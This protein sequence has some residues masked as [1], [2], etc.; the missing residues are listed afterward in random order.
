MQRNHI[1]KKRT[2][3]IVKR[4]FKFKMGTSGLFSLK[5]QR[6]ELV[7]IRGFKKMMRRKYL[8]G[9]TRFRFRKI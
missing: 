4:K 6:F 7:Y 9:H 1:F 2:Q 3:T 8:K 5:P